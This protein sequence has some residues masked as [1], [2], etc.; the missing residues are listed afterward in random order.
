MNIWA[1][2]MTLGAL[3][4]LGLALGG[5][6]AEVPPVDASGLQGVY[7]RKATWQETM[8]AT[9]EA[10]IARDSAWIASSK[11]DASPVPGVTFG[12]WWRVGPLSVADVPDGESGVDVPLA[13]ERELDHSKPIGDAKWEQS[14]ELKDG[15]DIR[16]SSPAP[17]PRPGQKAARVMYFARTI[18]A[19]EAE[20]VVVTFRWGGC[21]DN[22]LQ[23]PWWRGMNVWL[24]GEK[25]F[26][27]HRG[28]PYTGHDHNARLSL[29]KGDNRLL[30]KVVGGEQGFC[31][32]FRC[33]GAGEV[34]AGMREGKRAGGTSE[35][36]P[37][38]EHFLNPLWNRLAAD[39]STSVQRR[40][41]NWERRDGIWDEP[42]PPGAVLELAE[43]YAARC[44]A[45]AKYSAQNAG[46][47]ART[48]ADLDAMRKFYYHSKRVAQAADPKFATEHESLRLALEDLIETF[49]TRYP[50]GPEYL[51]RAESLRRTLA[52]AMPKIQKNDPEADRG[53]DAAFDEYQDLRQEA[54][55]AN[56]LLDFE[57]LLL[58]KRFT[59]Y[60]VA[61]IHNCLEPGQPINW[62]GNSSLPTHGYDN[63]IAVLSP[64]RP[65]GRMTTLYRP[66]ETPF[67]GD[68]DLH[69]DAN[70]LVFSSVN[71]AGHWH[72]F[73]IGS[74]GSGLRQVSKGDSPDV[75]NFDPCYLPDGRIVF[76]S[77]AP[78]QGVLCSSHH[79]L[80]ANLYVMNGDG[81][82]MRRLCWD[83]EMDWHPAVMNDGRVVYSRFEYAD[84]NHF[85]GRPL[86]AMNPDG[87]GQRSIYKSN[88]YFPP[89]LMF[90]RSVPE[91]SKVVAVA[92]SHHGG[93]RKGGLVVLDPSISHYEAE[94]IVYMNPPGSKERIEPR[95]DELYSVNA[96]PA[97]LN[98]Y[99]LSEK[100]FLVACRPTKDRAWGIYLADVFDNLVL[101]RE[102]AEYAL[103]EPIP[104]V[105][106]PTPPV[107][108]DRIDL[109]RH[110]AEVYLADIYRGP[111][112]ANVP[113]GTVKAL[114]VYALNYGY[115][116]HNGWAMTGTFDIRRILGTVP[117]EPDGSASFRV[118]ANTPISF[119]PLDE[120]GQA[121][122]LMRSWYTAMPG[123]KV[124]CV[125]CHERAR[126]VPLPGPRMAFA[127]PPSDIQPW[128]GPVRGVSFNQDVAPVLVRHCAGC[129]DDKGR[130]I[131]RLSGDALRLYANRP[132][133]QSDYHLRIAGEYHADTSELVRILKKGH[134]GVKLDA[135]DMDR[136]VTWIDLGTPDR[137]SWGEG[138]RGIPFNQHQ[139]R[140]ETRRRYENMDVDYEA[141]PQLPAQ[142]L[143]PVVA[144]QPEQQPPVVAVACPDWPFDAV[145]AVRRQKAAGPDT[146][147]QI[148]LGADS[149]GKPTIL[150]MVLVPAGDFVMGDASGPSDERPATRVRIARP[151]WI[152]R[153][154]IS[155]RQFSAFDPAHDSD[156][157]DDASSGAN[158][159]RSR[160][161]PLNRP[162]QPVVRI[163]WDQ[164]MAFCRWLS[165]KTGVTCRL[166]TEAQWEYACRAGS[167]L[168]LSFGAVESD[169]SK[170][171]NLADASFFKAPKYP[172]HK[173][174]A[175]QRFDDKAGVTAPVG[176]YEPNV[177][178]LCDMH[179]NVAEWTLSLYHP[180]PY[181][182]G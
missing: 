134:H 56:P 139:R 102:D 120:G 90:P 45:G 55:L 179:G 118:P 103:Y 126:D 89:G 165:T 117:V 37:P 112:L 71:K 42:W 161:I 169:F 35:V 163:S 12:S 113:R 152:S 137:A 22:L 83:Q 53:F 131:P 123:E 98:P 182:D 49:G 59:G 153:C 66:T 168:P 175:D 114:R 107:I 58:V 171:A 31:F 76:A 111:G 141:L 178:G 170:H 43:R 124:S 6:A 9:R 136:I 41:M 51:R 116:D 34:L 52:D 92:T 69:W 97:F 122:Q 48:S 156:L 95:I 147:R 140:M 129:H 44:G 108:P 106:R 18:T 173:N 75:E 11:G 62:Q 93:R 27:M 162:E 96:Y 7:A 61:G 46:G 146:R 14:P 30:V 60:S 110:D 166:P 39:F 23:T 167:A 81:T 28:F 10:M 38:A 13:P 57:R 174:A 143:T 101:L 99:P 130:K 65:D 145:E 133:K 74:D 16:V 132:H 104:L 26:R 79:D 8:Y 87:T 17:A 109:A 54:L 151:F 25:V 115:R 172:G 177:W 105:K 33:L 127:K 20:K 47:A 77:T 100:Y 160:G 29:R 36:W 180:Y 157:W 138:G 4:A 144:A 67:V 50:K 1:K 125:G 15:L 150:D 154:E 64:V 128:Y 176:S 72:V 68:V 78:L 5:H 19:R 32:G 80:V 148:A 40:Q 158:S 91:S 70:R 24:N 94:G 88:S 135:E 86:M 21:P 3:I 181:D 142:R 84:I 2:R 164:A 63:E 82:G 155:N 121:I 149:D 85:F 159:T 73:E 119:Q